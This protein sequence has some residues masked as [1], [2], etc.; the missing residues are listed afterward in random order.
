MPVFAERFMLP[1]LAAVVTAVAFIN[2]MKWD[3]QSRAAL[4][5]GT[6]ALAFLV[7]HQ[8]HLRNEAIRIG[9]GPAPAAPAPSPPARISG[10]ASTEGAN[11]PA[12][13]GDGNTF[14]YGSAGPKSSPKARNRQSKK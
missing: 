8:I 13:T 9:T 12:N 10:P 6:V 4:L 14:S 5:I 11:S 1:V 2:P 3:W 7:S